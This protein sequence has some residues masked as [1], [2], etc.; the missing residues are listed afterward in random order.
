M[1]I[2]RVSTIGFDILRKHESIL[3]QQE[4]EAMEATY[5][6]RMMK[7]REI[8]NKEQAEVMKKQQLLS[9]QL[10]LLQNELKQA[11][12]RKKLEATQEVIH[13]LKCSS[14]SDKVTYKPEAVSVSSCDYYHGPISW[15]ESSE[16]LEDCAEGTFLVRDSQDPQF[17]YSLSFQRGKKEGGP[18]SV[19]IRQDKGRWSLDSQESIHHLMPS[20]SSTVD[21]IK[22]YVNLTVGGSEDYP[23][24]LRTGLRRRRRT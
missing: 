11:E 17:L 21:L 12:L 20:F 15:Q 7:Q 9:L 19:R 2:S 24:K 18:T 3:R 16:L 6:A 13:S 10:E 22:Y 8:L 1:E 4:R 5:K 14:P 23:I